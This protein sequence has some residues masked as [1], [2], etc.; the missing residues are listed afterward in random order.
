M[1]NYYNIGDFMGRSGIKSEKTTYLYAGNKLK[2][3]LNTL[4]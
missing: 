4:K 1:L 2:N 3:V